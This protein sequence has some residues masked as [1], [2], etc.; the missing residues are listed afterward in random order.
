MFW[1]GSVGISVLL[2]VLGLLVPR[3]TAVRH[4]AAAALVT[5][6]VC[7]LLGVLLGSAAGRP[8][9]DALAGID[10]GY[11]V[12]ELA[13]AIAVAATALPYLSRPVHRA[14]SLLVA[15]AVLAAVCGGEA[16]PVNAI[17]SVALG[18]G[19]AAG[20]APGP[21][22][23]A[24]PAAGGRGDALDR[25]P[26]RRGHGHHPGPPPGLGGRAVHRP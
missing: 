2:V 14:V 25:G 20:P 5:W 7:V 15:L 11:P 19:I 24:G 12:T 18:W 26:E 22:L 13:V 21:G 6:G 16:L 3:L 17:S 8:P 1:I 4:V 23:A 9:T 10:T